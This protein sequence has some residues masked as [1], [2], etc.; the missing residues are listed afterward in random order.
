M[1]SDFRPKGRFERAHTGTI[2]L[3]EIGELPLHQSKGKIHGKNGAAE[4]LGINPSS[5][6]SRM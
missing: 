1:N 2:L 3:D 4:L 5:L 6:R